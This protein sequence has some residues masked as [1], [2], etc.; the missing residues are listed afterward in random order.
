MGLR[1][2]VVSVHGC[3]SLVPGAREAGGMNVYI[4][5]LSREL[6]RQGVTVDIF[7]RWHDPADPQMEWLAPNAR[8]I[9]LEAGGRGFLSKDG[10]FPHLPEFRDRLVAFAEAEGLRHDAVHSHYWLSGWVG[11]DLQQRWGIPH[12]SMFHTLGAVKNQVRAGERE[13]A[14]RIATEHAIVDAADAIV[15]ASP[16]EQ[17]HLNRLHPGAAGRVH[18]I[19]CGVD[20][21]VFRPQDMAAARQRLGL[22]GER[23]LLFVG[24]PDPLKGLE[25]LIGATSLLEH[26][27][28][29]RVL[30]VGGEGDQ[31]DPAYVAV[32]ALASTLNVAGQVSYSGAVAQNV[33]PLYYNAADVCVVPSYYESFGLVAL[34]AMACGTP[35]VASRVG[36]LQSTVRDGETGFLVPWHCPEPFAERLDLLL[37]NET[38][39]ASLGQAARASAQTYRW[40]A[41]AGSVIDL[42]HRL[43]AGRPKPEPQVNCNE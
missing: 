13:S 4:T 27:H 3:P 17:Q 26:P 2:A 22:N 29:V 7:S 41:V 36:G 35:V 15:V 23:I 16:Q 37:T 24:R 32:R 9:H 39:R 43:Q 30:V 6:A 11:A 1:I 25:I 19:P 38:L 34:E 28:G 40:P 18:V 10:I 21:E 14:L 42:Y 33:L 8:V 31:S 20:V 5:T 12:V